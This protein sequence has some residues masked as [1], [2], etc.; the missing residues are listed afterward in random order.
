VVDLQNKIIELATSIRAFLKSL[1]DSRLDSFL[2]DW[3]SPQYRMRP[4]VACSLPILSWLPAAVKAA[5][6]QTEL[7]VRMLASLANQ[8]TWGQTYSEQDFGA[9]FLERYGWTEMMAR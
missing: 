8:L 9:E 7:M 5:D 6:K 1:N 4:V 3:P 2:A